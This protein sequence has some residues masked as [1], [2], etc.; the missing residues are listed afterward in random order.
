VSLPVD[1]AALRDA[2]AEHGP[3]A[4]LVTVNADGTPHVVSAVVTCEADALTAPA[5]RTTRASAAARPAVALL[6]PP[7]PDPA[8]SLIVDATYRGTAGVDAIAVEP[9]SAVL[10][11][12]ADAAGDGPTCIAVGEAPSAS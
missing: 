7:G 6:W 2:I 9:H 1:L 3:A 10:H 4:Y 12:V 11:R 5:G 8:Y